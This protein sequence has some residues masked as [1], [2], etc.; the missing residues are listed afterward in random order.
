MKLKAFINFFSY[1]HVV[2]LQLF[3]HLAQVSTNFKICSHVKV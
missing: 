2:C 1:E 3:A